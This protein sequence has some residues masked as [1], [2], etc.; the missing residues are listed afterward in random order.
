MLRY[1]HLVDL[2]KKK[3]ELEEAEHNSEDQEQISEKQEGNLQENKTSIS[4][5]DSIT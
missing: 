1:K 3:K 4:D 5:E 2:V